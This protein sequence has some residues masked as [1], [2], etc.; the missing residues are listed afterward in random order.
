M[1]E[2]LP[3]VFFVKNSSLFIGELL[4]PEQTDEKEQQTG[5]LPEAES[6]K[7]EEEVEEE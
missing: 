3:G 5:K 1:A 7:R 6:E 2:D 4:A